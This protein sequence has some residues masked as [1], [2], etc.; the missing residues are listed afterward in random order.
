MYDDDEGGSM[1]EPKPATM[2][3]MHSGIIGKQQ[4]NSYRKLLSL[5]N[6]EEE[7]NAMLKLDPPLS[8]NR[9]SNIMNERSKFGRSSALEEYY[10]D[11]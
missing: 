11:Y 5:S 3:S 9:H 6:S 4:D 8:N 10:S 2:L 7:S 1:N